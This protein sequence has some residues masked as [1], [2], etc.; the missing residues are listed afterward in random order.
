MVYYKKKT[1][2]S[3]Y[4]AVIVIRTGKRLVELE[5]QPEIA[6]VRNAIIRTE[7][8]VSQYFTPVQNPL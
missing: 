2:C 6:L 8:V 7:F 3:H 1:I 4:D 5:S